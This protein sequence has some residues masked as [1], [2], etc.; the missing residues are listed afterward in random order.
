MGAVA[1]AP[2]DGGWKLAPTTSSCT[3][4][5]AAAA[6]DADAA[7]T[8][9]TAAGKTVSMTLGLLELKSSS[10]SPASDHSA[11]SWRT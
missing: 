11:P 1:L 7:S 2:P 9:G 3:E 6:E 10:V 4:E 8:I 5:A